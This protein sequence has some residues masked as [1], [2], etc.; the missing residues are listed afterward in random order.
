MGPWA[1][2]ILADYGAD[3]IKVEPPGGDIIRTAG[4]M[5]NALMG[6]V[7]LNSSRGKR[8][9]VLDLKRSPDREALLKLCNRRRLHPQR[10]APSDGT[11]RSWVRRSQGGEPEDRLRESTRLRSC[12]AE[13]RPPGL[14]RSDSRRVRARFAFHGFR[15][16]A[17]IRSGIGCGSLRRHHGRQCCAC[18]VAS[19]RVA[20]GQGQAIDVPMFETMV[21][22][23]LSDH[24]G[25]HTFEPRSD[26]SVINALTVPASVQKRRA[27]VCACGLQRCALGYVLSNHRKHG[28]LL[29]GWTRRS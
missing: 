22:L 10:A 28:T 3:V 5:R 29:I 23:V 7:F 15:R 1:T 16:R 20:R 14:R 17:T 11:A 27:F 2:H 13:S 21:E 8:S 25:G 18:G 9:I 6:P 26:R 19:A 4:P 24:L 12:W